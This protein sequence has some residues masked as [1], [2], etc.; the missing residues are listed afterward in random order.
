MKLFPD[1]DLKASQSFVPPSI[2][3]FILTLV[4]KSLGKPSALGNYA[5]RTCIYEVVGPDTRCRVPKDEG[6]GCSELDFYCILEFLSKA[7]PL[8]GH[9]I[10]RALYKAS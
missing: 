3:L 4:Q 8:V 2:S 1:C 5:R 10:T 9:C 7:R 6:S